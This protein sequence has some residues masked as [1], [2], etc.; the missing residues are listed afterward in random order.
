MP[1]YRFFYN[2]TFYKDEEIIISSDELHHLHVM[3]K[4]LNENVEIINGKNQLAEA[5]IINLTPKSATLKITKIITKTPEKTKIIL[6]QPLLRPQKLDLILEKG[7]E[8]GI[9]EF[10]LYPAEYSEIKEISKNREERINS[11]LISAV[12]QCGRLDMPKVSIIDNISLLLSYDYSYLYGDLETTNRINT[13]EI[14]KQD[15]CIVI[16]PEK[17]FSKKEKDFL[18]NKLKAHP[19]NINSNILKT[20]TA[21]VATAAICKYLFN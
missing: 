12:K 5:K 13:E 2:S 17:G 9:D 16:G 15:I 19:I 10:I 7:T 14:T 11:I 6:A 4:K 3:R 8:L 20:E 18:Q 1:H 21:S